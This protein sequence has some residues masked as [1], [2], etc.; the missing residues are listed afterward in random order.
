[1]AR[2]RLLFLDEDLDKR[3][4]R[5]LVLRGRR[6]ESIYRTELQGSTDAELLDALND[7]Y[8]ADVVLV[9][10]NDGM[11]IENGDGFQVGQVALATIDTEH[12]DGYHLNEW[13]CEAVHAGRTRC[14]PSEDVP[15]VVELRDDG[16]GVMVRR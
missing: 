4:R 2:E 5:E 3:L 13:R 8:G 10:G 7:L 6:A 16:P 11:P 14:R 9:T 12:P 15:F 1:M